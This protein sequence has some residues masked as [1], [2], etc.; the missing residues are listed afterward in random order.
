[1]G[2][3]FSKLCRLLTHRTYFCVYL[4][5]ET[6]IFC[7]TDSHHHKPV[8]AVYRWL[9]HTSCAYAIA[10]AIYCHDLFFSL[11]YDI[12]AV[13]H[14]TVSLLGIR[15]RYCSNA[16]FC[17]RLELWPG[18]VTAVRHY[19]G[20]LL[21][22]TDVSHRTLRT[23]TVLDV[24]YELYQKYPRNFQEEVSR[25]LIGSVVLTRWV[26]LEYVDSSRTR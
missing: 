3:T 23:D 12:S 19:E 17:G 2:S 25:R 26:A 7:T 24:M 14:L 15:T 9:C 4:W 13:V 10:A 8:L 18:Y 22:V 1:M 21:L 16:V 20:G 5:I 6:R 11:V